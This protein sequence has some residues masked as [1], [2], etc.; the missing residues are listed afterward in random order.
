VIGMNDG[1]KTNFFTNEQIEIISSATE[2]AEEIVFNHW[3]FSQN[4]WLKRRFDI[5]T[6]KNLS[7]NEIV[8]NQFAQLLSY[9]VVPKNKLLK[10][11]KF[12]VYHIC[13]QDHCILP[14]LDENP[15]F[16]LFALMLYIITHELIHVVRFS[17]YKVSHIE[18]NELIVQN[19]EKKVHIKTYELLKKINNNSL[20]FIFDFYSKWREL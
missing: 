17:T 8:N 10:S 1:K 18:P 13:L 20:Q 5:K 7:A 3:K 15:S 16:E 11:D 2:I 12:I 14:F 19:E 6:Q 4:D 9:D